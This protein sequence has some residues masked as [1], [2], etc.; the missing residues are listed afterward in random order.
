M[1]TK[2]KIVIGSALVL[3]LCGVIVA[4]AR[5]DWFGR[6]A[7][8]A[9]RKRAEG[10]WNARVA[11]D[12]KA[13]AP[14]VHPLQKSIQENSILV[15]DSYEVTGVKVEGDEALVGIKA[16]YRLKH[17]MTSKLERELTHEDKWVRYNGE[18]YHGLHPVGLGELLRQGLGKWKPPT[19][20][21]PSPASPEASTDQAQRR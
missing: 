20:P 9:V 10:Y 16:K 6:G 7:E 21:S 14:Y 5:P 8:T 15:T 13:L 11:G 3:S 4:L 19:G 2:K 18:W 12:P 1:K 17:P